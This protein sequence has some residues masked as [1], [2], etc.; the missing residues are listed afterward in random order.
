MEVS[1]VAVST[2]QASGGVNTL[3]QPEQKTAEA[4]RNN[5]S[6]VA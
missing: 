5:G 3:S 2:Q 1:N 4:E 6:K